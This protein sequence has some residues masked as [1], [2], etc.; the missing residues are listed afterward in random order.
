MGNRPRAP[1]ITTMDDR[2]SWK[3]QHP[4]ETHKH[5]KPQRMI[6]HPPSARV[7]R[8]KAEHRHSAPAKVS[9]VF[10]DD[11]DDREFSPAHSKLGGKVL[12]LNG[13]YEPLAI[14]NVEK[15][16]ILLYLAK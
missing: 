11:D 5:K 10:V 1:N 9:Q 14:T 13:N 6:A 12:I 15:A 4:F 7:T 8:V 2:T 3:E 16:I